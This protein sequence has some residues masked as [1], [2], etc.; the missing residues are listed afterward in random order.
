M[1]ESPGILQCEHIGSCVHGHTMSGFA[2]LFCCC[3][4]GGQINLHSYYCMGSVLECEGTKETSWSL[5]F[6]FQPMLF[7]IAV[8]W[9]Y[10]SASGTPTEEWVGAFLKKPFKKER[11]GKTT[12]ETR[13]YHSRYFRTMLLGL[14]LPDKPPFIWVTIQHICDP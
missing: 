14:I 5:T 11:K 12:T 7:V 4:C 2:R 13:E 10:A 8:G 6:S 9:V 1:K 3:D